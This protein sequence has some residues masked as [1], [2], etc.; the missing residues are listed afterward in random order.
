M[1]HKGNTT[2]KSM[3]ASHNKHRFKIAVAGLLAVAMVAVLLFDWRYL[4][5]DH[6]KESAADLKRYTEAHY[7]TA[8]L[9]FIGL[10][11][12][13][14]ASFLPGD[15][16]MPVIGGLLFGTVAGSAFT[17]AGSTLGATLAFLTA[18]Y[19]LQGWV[20]DKAGER[21]QRLQ[22]G[23]SRYGF[24]YLLPLRMAPILP[25]FVVNFGAGLTHVPLTTYVLAT[26][27]GI[28]PSTVVYAHAAKK[29]ESANGIQ[30]L[31]SPTIF[32]SLIGVAALT[33]IPTIWW[34]RRQRSRGSRRGN[35]RVG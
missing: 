35:Q 5:W 14:T 6:L 19:L 18:R 23:F 30:D 27:L 12:L 34:T 9:V 32:W 31:T 24:N 22:H 21:V 8:M 3:A 2:S 15:T 7:V 25:S 17:V 29:V 13:Q 28:L 1:C 20:Q 10:T 16:L 11:S 33:F 4:S 26:V